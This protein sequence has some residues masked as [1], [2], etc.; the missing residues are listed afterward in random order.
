MYNCSKLGENDYNCSLSESDKLP[1]N[2]VYFFSLNYIGT[3]IVHENQELPLQKQYISD[4]Y[5]FSF[6]DK[7]NIFYQKWKTIK[8]TENKGIIGALSF[9]KSKEYYGGVMMNDKMA[10]VDLPE[11]LEN[12]FKVRGMKI[13]CGIIIYGP[14][15]NIFDK[16]NRSK[17]TILELISNICSLSLTI[18]N[19][20]IFIYCGFFS[21]NFDN[22]KI[23]E[24]ILSKRKKVISAKRQ[25]ILYV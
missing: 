25:H 1:N 22:Y 17:K 13:L 4:I 7:S 11:E 18:Y 9:G 15:V 20:F 14:S 3:K 2:I 23:I 21:N 10:I 19:V 24:K 8:Y 5:Y 6:G 12:R 16:Y